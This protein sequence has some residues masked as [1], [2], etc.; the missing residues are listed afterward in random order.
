MKFNKKGEN[1]L[2][3]YKLLSVFFQNSNNENNDATL[4]LHFDFILTQIFKKFIYNKNCEGNKII[5]NQP[6][7]FQKQ[8]DG[9]F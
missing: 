8:I 3:L 9:L 1:V 7:E 2:L 5:L 6:S 4:Q